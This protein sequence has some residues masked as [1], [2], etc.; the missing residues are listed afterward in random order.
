MSWEYKSS[1][2]FFHL[3]MFEHFIHDWRNTRFLPGFFSKRELDESNSS[4]VILPFLLFNLSYQVVVVSGVRVFDVFL[5][6][7][8]L[9]FL[10]LL[11]QHK[12]VLHECSFVG[13]NR[14][15]RP[16]SSEGGHKNPGSLSR[17][18]DQE[19]YEKWW[20]PG[21]PRSRIRPHRP[22]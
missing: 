18:Q 16:R 17:P 15:E 2:N 5:Q 1:Y 3:F 4:I 20:Q 14:S 10:P 6:H 13:R 11:L 8:R 12:Y 19:E 7:A 21:G 22:R 9:S